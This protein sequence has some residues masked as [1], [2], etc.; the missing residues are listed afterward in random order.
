MSGA[1]QS[2]LD[3]TLALIDAGGRGPAD[4]FHNRSVFPH[5]DAQRRVDPVGFPPP[6][7]YERLR[8][9]KITNFDIP[10]LVAEALERAPTSNAVIASDVIARGCGHHMDRHY[11][12]GLCPPCYLRNSLTPGTNMPSKNSAPERWVSDYALRHLNSTLATVCVDVNGPRFKRALCG[13][14]VLHPSTVGAWAELKDT[15]RERVVCAMRYAEVRAC[16]MRELAATTEPGHELVAIARRQHAFQRMR[17][18]LDELY[19]VM[20]TTIIE[21]DVQARIDRF[22]AAPLGE[23]RQRNRIVPYEILDTQEFD[24]LYAIRYNRRITRASRRRKDN[25]AVGDIWPMRLTLPDEP[26]EDLRE[27]YVA[28]GSP[29]PKRDR[30]GFRRFTDVQR[31]LRHYLKRQVTNVRAVLDLPPPTPAHPAAPAATTNAPTDSA[32]RSEDAQESQATTQDTQT[33]AREARALAAEAQALVDQLEQGTQ[34]PTA[35]IKPLANWKEP[36]TAPNCSSSESE[37]EQTPAELLRDLGLV[38]TSSTRPTDTHERRHALSR[39]GASPRRMTRAQWRRHVAAPPTPASA[40]PLGSVEDFG[41]DARGTSTPQR[42]RGRPRTP[43]VVQPC[44]STP[45]APSEP[46]SPPPS[47]TADTTRETEPLQQ[48]ARD[49]TSSGED[50]TTGEHAAVDPPPPSEADSDLP[51]PASECAP[52]VIVPEAGATAPIYVTDDMLRERFIKHF[53]NR[54]KEAT[55]HP[56]RQKVINRPAP[57]TRMVRDDA[58][59][60]IYLRDPMRHEG[61]HTTVQPA[62]ETSRPTTFTAWGRFNHLLDTNQPQFLPSEVLNLTHISQFGS[63]DIKQNLQNKQDLE[64]RAKRGEKIA[65]SER[66][67]QPDLHPVVL[68]IVCEQ[69]AQRRRDLRLAERDALPQV[70]YA[71]LLGELMELGSFE[72][73]NPLLSLYGYVCPATAYEGCELRV[74][75]DSWIATTPLALQH[76]ATLAN[77]ALVQNSVMHYSCDSVM[78]QFESQRQMPTMTIDP[79]HVYFANTVR[80]LQGVLLQQTAQLAAAA[81]HTKYMLRDAI[82]RC[83]SHEVRRGILS[84]PLL[85]DDKLWVPLDEEPEEYDFETLMKRHGIRRAPPVVHR[86]VEE[87]DK[88]MLGLASFDDVWMNRKSTTQMYQR[89]KRSQKEDYIIKAQAQALDPRFDVHPDDT[90]TA[91]YPTDTRTFEEIL[92]TLHEDDSDVEAEAAARR[93]RRERRRKRRARREQGKTPPKE[94]ATAK[95]GE[96]EGKQQENDDDEDSDPSDP[97]CS[98]ID[99]ATEEELATSDEYD[100]ED[101]RQEAAGTKPKGGRLPVHISEAEVQALFKAGASDYQP[102]AGE[103]PKPLSLVEALEALGA[104]KANRH[105]LLKSAQRLRAERDLQIVYWQERQLRAAEAA[106]EGE[107]RTR[108]WRARTV[109]L[110]LAKLHYNRLPPKDKA[111]YDRLMLSLR[112]YLEATTPL[113][114]QDAAAIHARIKF[115]LKKLPARQVKKPFTQKRVKDMNPEERRIH[116]AKLRRNQKRVKEI[117]RERGCTAA[118]AREIV[119]EEDQ[120]AAMTEQELESAAALEPVLEDVPVQSERVDEAATQA[121]GDA[122][123]SGPRKKRAKHRHEDS[124]DEEIPVFTG[125]MFVDEQVA[126]LEAGHYETSE[127]EEESYDSYEEDAATGKRKVVRRRRAKKATTQ[128]ESSS[129]SNSSA[130]TDDT[131]NEDDLEKPPGDSSSGDEGDGAA[132]KPPA[133]AQHG[134]ESR[135]WEQIAEGTRQQPVDPVAPV[136]PDV[137][138]GGGSADVDSSLRAPADKL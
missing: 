48:E 104:T 117:C 15:P 10:P 68:E 73:E 135:T 44:A 1:E 70:H 84:Q 24:T 71:H 82:T 51:P 99:D 7:Q 116:R 127:E 86:D 57:I 109:K 55:I 53:K 60:P 101:E 43:I 78:A 136:A 98:F 67:F 20:S 94:A 56:T 34:R 87:K 2:D 130:S 108:E 29:L 66:R 17:S 137:T 64:K 111:A 90:A 97:D 35:P 102:L 88:R 23:I 91:R 61:S 59:E 106:P 131:V 112:P 30:R 3:S 58:D 19:R 25:R 132:Q 26:L 114:P 120:Q 89:L 4:R 85:Q 50:A 125:N 83:C 74:D 134:S 31:F 54:C 126:T 27:F 133:A 21:N 45:N 38:S 128:D 80:Q 138:A 93:K 69:D 105:K 22:L 33:V 121:P 124:P 110:C 40:I 28:D 49:A 41:A 76:A 123:A 119:L 13:D 129:S 103:R 5:A 47:T 32:P 79:L 100:S 8:L 107:K 118:E 65:A 96:G 115:R 75:D 113:V 9:D 122:S 72:V 18:E 36:S 62:Y 46:Q 39:A 16:E 14:V 52:R 95:A 11:A 92:E 77:C 37:G 42:Q 12:S 6:L 63:M 81:Q